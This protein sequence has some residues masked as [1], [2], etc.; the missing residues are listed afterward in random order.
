MTT[1]S[2]RSTSHT[3]AS[4]R[5][6][7]S[8]ASRPSCGG[9]PVSPA[10]SSAISSRPVPIWSRPREVAAAAGDP[11]LVARVTV[12]L[13]FEV[14]HGGDLHGALAMLDAAEADVS[15][16]DLAQLSNPA[17]CA[18]LSAR[19]ARRRRRRP[20]VGARSGGADRRL[21]D[22]PHGARQPRRHPESARRSTRTRG[23]GCTRRSRSPRRSASSRPV[24]WR[25]PTSPTSRRARATS[26][27]HSTPSP[28][29]RTATGKRGR[30]A[31]CRDCT[32]TTPSRSP[33]PTCSTTPSS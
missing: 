15:D 16:A 12:S 27:R 7:S 26:P 31:S 10:A 5:G 28:R 3:S 19:P 22:R 32:P 29:P 9:S 23:S 8:T 4:P 30:S 11:S 1:R 24:P 14:G 33:T 6:R 21:A 17:R 25:S 18:Q 2:A 13:A 20:D